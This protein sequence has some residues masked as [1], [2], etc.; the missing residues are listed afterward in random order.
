[1]REGR[2]CSNKERLLKQLILKGKDPCNEFV[3]KMKACHSFY[4]RFCETMESQRGVGKH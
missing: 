1:M 3:E 4:T 2:G